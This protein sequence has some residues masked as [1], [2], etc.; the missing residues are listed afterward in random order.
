VLDLDTDLELHRLSH[1]PG[2]AAISRP[3]T[4]R[5]VVVL[6]GS[7]DLYDRIREEPTVWP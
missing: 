1:G 6:S 2:D 4:R 5:V 3:P 7:D